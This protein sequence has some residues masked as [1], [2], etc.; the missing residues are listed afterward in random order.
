[1]SSLLFAFVGSFLVSF[2]ARDQLLVARLR[3]ALGPSTSLLAVAILSSTATAFIAAWI[4]GQLSQIMSAS[5]ATMFV[6]FA[7]LAAAFEL[8]WP[9]RVAKQEEPTSSLG[10]I[11][12][13]LFAR[14]ISDASRFVILALAVAL[15]SPALAGLGGAIAGSATVAIGWALSE[16]LE[17]KVPLRPI[18]VSLALALA[19]VAVII[20]L[21][22]RGIIE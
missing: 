22:A 11:F 15:A 18:R 8:A 20:G 12:I 13:V 14:Q 7:L 3:T 21:S 2:G 9:N 6:A 16:E 10:A 1:M 17:R 19:T 5:A 4:G